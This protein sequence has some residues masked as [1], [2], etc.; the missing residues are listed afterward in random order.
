MSR[1][2]PLLRNPP[3]AHVRGAHATR[4]FVEPI[5][6]GWGTGSPCSRNDWMYRGI[7]SAMSCSTSSREWPAATQPGRSGTYAPQ[8]SPSCSITT[9]YSVTT[10]PSRPA[11]LPPDRSQR[12]LRHL[13][14]WIACD[15]H[16]SRP[17]G[18]AELPVRAHLPVEAPALALQCTDDVS[19]LHELRARERCDDLLEPSPSRR[20]RHPEVSRRGSVR[21]GK[22]LV[23][24]S[25]PPASHSANLEPLLEGPA[26]TLAARHTKV[27]RAGTGDHDLRASAPAGGAS[28]RTRTRRPRVQPQPASPA[29]HRR[30][31]ADPAT[32]RSR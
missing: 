20:D 15:R 24:E 19:H 13:V 21:Q 6:V 17:V 8:A 27:R 26:I 7:A 32:R 5:A 12:T 10:L 23:I 14:T 29:R 25:A 4:T 16:R 30:H 9:T 11:G 28:R 2:R 31:Q 18:M 3:R 1:R 22:A